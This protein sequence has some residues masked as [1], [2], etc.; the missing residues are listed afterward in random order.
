MHTSPVT[1]IVNSSS[2]IR[3]VYLPPTR[4]SRGSEAYRRWR[5]APLSTMSTATTV[6][7]TILALGA[8]APTHADLLL[9]HKRFRDS[10]SPKDSIK[11]DIDADAL[12][13]SD[14]DV[15]AAEVTADMD[16]EARVDAGIGIE[17]ED[18]IKDEDEGDAESSDR[19]TIEVRMDVVAGI[20]I[21]DEVESLIASG[22]R[23]GL[24]D[25]VAALE[26]SNARLRNTLRM[27]SVRADRLRRCMGFIEDELRQIH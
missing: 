23:V 18:D 12:A 15:A 27:E 26:R 21:P 4:T 11:D 2:P 5:S 6:P 8:L 10:I 24:L 25:H 22:E 17:V 9:P 19:G 3:F 16:V 14:A 1:T 20:D 13:D 7:S